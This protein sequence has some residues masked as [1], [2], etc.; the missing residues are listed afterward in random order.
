MPGS[1]YLLV[2]GKLMSKLCETWISKYTMDEIHRG[3]NSYQTTRSSGNISPPHSLKHD[4]FLHKHSRTRLA[5]PREAFGKA[6]KSG[7]G[8]DSDPEARGA[9]GKV[10]RNQTQLRKCKTGNVQ[11]KAKAIQNHL[12]QEKQPFLHL[13]TA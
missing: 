7:E 12:R 2:E 4:V 13:T 8:R 6:S 3:P 9:G 5:L 11:R 1:N 10:Q